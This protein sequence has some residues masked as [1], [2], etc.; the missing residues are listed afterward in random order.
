MKKTTSRRPEKKSNLKRDRAVR[1]AA[2]ARSSRRWELTL[3]KGRRSLP[4][5]LSRKRSRVKTAEVV[6]GL[7]RSAAYQRL[8]TDPR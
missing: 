2:E 8:V 6:T 7:F 1:L 3:L 4:L 5:T